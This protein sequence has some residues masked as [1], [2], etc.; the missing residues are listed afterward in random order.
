MW[1]CPK[2]IWPKTYIPQL[3]LKICNSL[4]AST[5]IFLE[6]S[7]IFVRDWVLENNQLLGVSRKN[8]NIGPKFFLSSSTSRNP[9]SQD[10][11]NKG[12]ISITLLFVVLRN[13][14]LH[15]L[16]HVLCSEL[17]SLRFSMRIKCDIFVTLK[18]W[19]LVICQAVNPKVA[20]IVYVS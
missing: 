11:C 6:D 7:F 10:S 9:L 18:N 4:N 3:R 8:W 15:V 19:R 12:L 16:M 17:T 1:I 13:N 14:R 2:I 5:F 20:L